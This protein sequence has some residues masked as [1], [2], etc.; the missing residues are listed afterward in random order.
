[1]EDEKVIKISLE[2]L[3]ERD[4]LGNQAADASIILK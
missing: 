2:R 1:M 3:K 4:N